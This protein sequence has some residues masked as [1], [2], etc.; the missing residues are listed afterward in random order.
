[1]R[2]QAPHAQRRLVRALAA[3]L[4]AGALLHSGGAAALGLMQ[5][6]EAAAV[7][8]PT[9]QSAFQ[10][11]EAGKEYKAL[12]R[13]ALLPNLSANYSVSRNHSDLTIGKSFTQPQYY[14]RSAGVSLRQ[15]LFNLDAL[16]RYKQGIA[17]SAYNEA[18]FSGRTQEMIL[19]VTSAYIDALFG[20]EQLRLAQVQRDVL[21]EQRKVNDR[22]FAGGE[23]TK[24]DAL[25]TQARLDLAEAQVLEAQDNLQTQR[26]T[27]AA[28]VGGEV[29]TLD[30]LKP[31]FRFL[32]MPEGGF[33]G[34]R[35]LALERNPELQA[36]NFAIESARQEVNKS[37][38]GHLPRVD[39][40]GTYSKGN[41]ETLNTYNQESTTRAI[42]IQV[43][44]PLYSGGQVN[45]SSRQSVAS[46]E[47]AR[48]ELQAKSDKILVDLRKQYAAVSSG[49]A[50]IQALDKAVSSG[51]L[52]VQATEQS[53]KGGV[54]INLDLLNAQ[55]Q[56]Y[57]STRDLAQARF[58]YLLGMLKLRAGAGTL[59]AGDVR[60]VAE[61]FVK[62]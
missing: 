50:R 59:G 3:A 7:N 4:A 21:V 30:G 47:K 29:D 45:A 25:E 40:V 23:G 31:D 12:G 37:R 5:A 56:L 11:A 61:Y 19:R 28:L 62:R 52:L 6:Y 24:T 10:D 16:A 60:E 35:Q 57:T 2:H 38:A 49:M 36:Q 20:Q 33:E 41:S 15:P 18:T 17:Q 8:D 54:R 53:I 32:P 44:V 48:A 14:S 39:F 43:S 13:S 46:L 27:L 58:T 9:F 51:K 42:G 1:M 26:A 34:W 55:Q 22:L